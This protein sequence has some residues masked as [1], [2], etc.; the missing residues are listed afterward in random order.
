MVTAS[1]IDSFEETLEAVPV[2]AIFIP[3]IA[4]MAGNAG[5]QSLAVAVRGLAVGTYGKDNK[6]K[7]LLREMTTGLLV[8]GTCGIIIIGVIYV[9]KGNL[10]LGLLVGIAILATLTVA[11]ISGA[12]IPLIME[13][14]N[15]DPAVASGPFITTLNDVTSVIIYFGMA[16]AFMGM[17]VS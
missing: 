8:G 4:G 1:L 14:F 13:K 11:T 16:T 15:I 9:W 12:L 5:T 2:V 10:F 7:L 3:L 6:L 17:L